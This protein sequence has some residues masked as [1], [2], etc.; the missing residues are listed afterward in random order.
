MQL[1]SV[2]RG[3]DWIRGRLALSTR[4]IYCAPPRW[5]YDTWRSSLP[6]NS[7]SRPTI[8]FA[9]FLPAFFFPLLNRKRVLSD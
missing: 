2:M 4:G 8:R 5:Q 1:H 7:T 9:F 6:A 3:V